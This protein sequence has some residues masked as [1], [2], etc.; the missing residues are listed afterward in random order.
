MYSSLYRRDLCPQPFI[1]NRP[2]K[3][4][5]LSPPKN[6]PKKERIVPQER[7]RRHTAVLGFERAHAVRTYISHC[8]Y[9]K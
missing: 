7:K 8:D 6:L 3:E 5:L 9:L 4:S 1:Q 2:M